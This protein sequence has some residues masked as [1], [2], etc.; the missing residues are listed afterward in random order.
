LFC[1]TNYEL[2]AYST[3]ATHRN[4]TFLFSLPKEL[5]TKEH[6]NN[7]RL[8]NLKICKEI[9]NLL[10]EGGLNFTL[11]TPEYKDLLSF[12][13]NE[14]STD[15]ALYLILN[16]DMLSAADLET[17]IAHVRLHAKDKENDP[18][19]LRFIDELAERHLATLTQIGVTITDQEKAFRQDIL[20]YLKKQWLTHKNKS[21]V[22]L[23]RQ[24]AL[25]Q[26]YLTPLATPEIAH[27]IA[28]Y[29]IADFQ[30]QK[31][32]YLPSHEKVQ[33]LLAQKTL[34][35]ASLDTRT[36][37]RIIAGITKLFKP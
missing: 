2:N 31:L 13:A 8:E 4:E 10:K 18:A 14:G 1:Y 23:L 36:M 19:A 21:V 28:Q 16:N 6:L 5:T 26:R 25:I 24:F 29:A 20:N 35:H 17:I 3:Y 9:L 32:D 34:E 7:E 27:K 11:K 33:E 12:L 22:K 37:R 30:D 15:L